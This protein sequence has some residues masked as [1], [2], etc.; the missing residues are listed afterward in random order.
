M[1]ARF[2]HYE[3]GSFAVVLT[4][5]IAK[6]N[7]NNAWLYY[8]DLETS[9]DSMI[10]LLSLSEDQSVFVWPRIFSCKFTE[11]HLVVSGVIWVMDFDLTR[12]L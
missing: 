5:L 7:K 4:G 8:K 3:K 6:V 10:F 12:V 11:D 1:R 2:Q 9:S